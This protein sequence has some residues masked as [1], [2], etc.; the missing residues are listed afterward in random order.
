[1]RDIA[2]WQEAMSRRQTSPA[3]MAALSD[4]LRQ[5]IWWDA[6]G[7]LAIAGGECGRRAR[8]ALRLAPIE[9]LWPDLAEGLRAAA[10]AA[11]E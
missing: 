4:L 2:D 10:D 5:E 3:A 9:D 7:R 8:E 6:S 1:M 11:A